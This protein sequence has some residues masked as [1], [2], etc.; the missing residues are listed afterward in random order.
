MHA[1]ILTHTHTHKNTPPPTG[2]L[3]T[4]SARRRPSA[5]A[6]AAAPTP[7]RGRPGPLVV[8]DNYDSFTYNLVQYLGDLGV[9]VAV[10]P[11]DAKTCAEIR[12]M[13]P[14]GVLISPGPGRNGRESERG[15]ESLGE[16]GAPPARNTKPRP[17]RTR[18]FGFA[19]AEVVWRAEEAEPPSK[20]RASA[21]GMGQE[22][23]PQA[24]VVEGKAFFSSTHAPQP[25]PPSP[26][27]TQAALKTLASPWR[28]SAPWAPTPRSLACAWATSASA[29]PLAGTSSAPPAV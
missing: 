22:Q 8:I 26:P 9:E 19:A 5:V 25:P 10:F 11:N 6:A 21:G 7:A 16:G 24:P 15:R 2:R 12:A 14:R 20:Q 3:P 27:P 18:H 28:P 1:S 4:P 29:R 23:P 13:R 17:L